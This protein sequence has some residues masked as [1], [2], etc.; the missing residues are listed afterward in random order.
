RARGRL[1]SDACSNHEHWAI[2]A[3]RMN[4]GQVFADDPEGEQ[5]RARKDRDHRRK[6]RKARD[7]AAGNEV[8][9]HDVRE[10]T[11]S[12]EGEKE[13]D[14]AWEAT[15]ARAVPRKHVERVA[16]HLPDRIVRCAD[17]AR[18]VFDGPPGEPA[19]APRQ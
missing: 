15:G 9:A 17:P 3:S 11:D 7:A 2:H 13:T 18:F 14:E 4:P 12:E 16:N 10:N 5:L 19:R 8:P 6:E 1:G